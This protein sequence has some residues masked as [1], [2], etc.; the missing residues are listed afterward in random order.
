MERDEREKMERERARLEDARARLEEQR[1]RVEDER[2]RLEDERDRILDEMEQLEEEAEEMNEDGKEAAR[3]KID[4]RM[5]KLRMKAERLTGLRHERLEKMAEHIEKALEGIQEQ[6]ENSIAG[7][8]FSAMGE[9]LHKGF[10]EMEKGLKN[11]EKEI[12]IS[13]ENDMKNVGILNLKDITPEELDKMGEIRNMGIIIAP[14]E[15]MGKISSK[16][17]KNMGTIVPFRKGWRIYSGHT[18]LDKSMLE[19]LEEPI[20]FIHTGYMSIDK[21]VT[22]DLIKAKIRAFHNYGQISATEETFGILMS[23]CLENY[24][25]ISKNGDAEDYDEEIP[26]PPRPPKQS[27]H[28]RED[29]E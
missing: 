9:S 2:Q 21:D 6:I 28:R 10:N 14:E 15:L 12:R 1:D 27:R 13:V 20:E 5:E 8:D 26:E 24:G 19:S 11:M 23:K 25:H 16:V 4:E 7:I 3:E 18:E 22:P 29:D 17:V